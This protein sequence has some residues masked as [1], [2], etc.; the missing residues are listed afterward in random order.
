MLSQGKIIK[1]VSN[2]YTVL[3]NHELLTATAR[4]KFRN[5]SLTPL[6]GDNVT[7]DLD[8]NQISE[9][10]PRKN[11]LSRPNV[12]N[13]DKALIVC[14]LKKPEFSSYLLDK[15][16]IN[17]LKNNITPVICF[18]KC[19]LLNFHEKRK[20][21]KIKKYYQHI[22]IK[23]FNNTNKFRLLSYLKNNIVVLAGQSGAGKSTLLNRLDKNLQ[24]KT[25]EISESLNRGKHTTRHTELFKIKKTYFVDTPGF[26]SLDLTDINKE[27]LKNYYPEFQNCHCKYQ[28]CLHYKETNCEVKEK[29]SSN[30]ILTSR[31][32][33][34]ITFLKEG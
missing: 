28:N 34:Y 27:D 26:G 30:E 14:S 33:N 9:I 21:N 18:T 3:T 12:A 29:V 5:E 13:I 1:I 11:V 2:Q 6:V 10:L 19:D 32:E 22:G 15:I 31:Y 23:V 16:L 8:T 17:V 4:G 7:I 20:I 24:L 25:D